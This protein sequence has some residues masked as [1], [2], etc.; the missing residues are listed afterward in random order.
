[1]GKLKFYDNLVEERR[2]EVKPLKKD[3]TLLTVI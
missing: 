2:L 3:Y 1:M